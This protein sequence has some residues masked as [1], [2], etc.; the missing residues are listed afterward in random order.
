MN[1][2]AISGLREILALLAVA[3][4]G[5]S[6]PTAATVALKAGL[7]SGT[8]TSSTGVHVFKG[9]PYAA[10]P[11][12]P[13][14][15]RPPQPVT[16]WDGLRKADEFGPKCM[17]GIPGLPAMSEDCLLLNVWT[18]AV[19]A[20][21]K[22]PV[23]VW[24]HGG[25]FTGG[26]GSSAQYNGEELAKKGAVLVTANYRLGVFG[27]FASPE[28]TAESE[29]HASGNYGLMDAIAVLRW[30][31]N[32]I[33][34]FGGDPRNVT[35]FGQSAGASMVSCLVGSP[36][37]KGL[38]RH[39]IAESGAWMGLRMSAM[40]PLSRAEQLSGKLME[41]TCASS[42]AE[43]RAKSAD[44]ILQNGRGTG[45][46]VDGWIVPEDLS[47]V[48]AEGRQNA[49]DLL[50]GSNKDEGAAA[51]KRTGAEL[52]TN[53]SRRLFGDRTD[54]YLKLYPAGTDAEA[55]LSQ[56]ASYRDEVGYEM[57]LWARLQQKLG[58]GKQSA[59][60][61]FVYYFTHEPPPS[62]AQPYKGAFHTAEIPY[63]FHNFEAGRQWTDGDQMLADQMS[64][65]WINFAKN[66]NPNG[67]GLPV[68]PEYRDKSVSEVMVLGEKFDVQPDAA[69]VA[70]WDGELMKLRAK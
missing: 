41:S 66:G 63:V 4:S 67:G 47:T 54:E 14:R 42:L 24:F 60:N 55:N 28:L 8:Q 22:R 53:I 69:R 2:R 45:P 6:A 18:G 9:V 62:P 5:V 7:V 70:F 31:R 15:W 50:V 29:H 52:F 10:P 38:F 37:A 35:I 39:A 23:M 17:Q 64:S 30:V 44:D 58:G 59:P 68:W 27:F 19:S 12:G 21:E 20:S 26:S 61:V 49:V 34:A 40:T 56:G 11:V 65:Y 48:F 36:E 13:L 33:A 16:H 46:I 43:L 3:T 57:R 1:R 32:N 51:L 25:G